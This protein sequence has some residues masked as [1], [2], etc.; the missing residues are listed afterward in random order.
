MTKISNYCMYKYTILNSSTNETLYL[1]IQDIF[2]LIKQNPD[3]KYYKILNGETI[4]IH[5]KTILNTEFICHR[6]NTV[7]ELLKI[8]TIFGVELDLRDGDYKQL[9]LQ[10]DPYIRGECFE[11][12]LKSYNH[13]TMI[14]NVKS[15]RIEPIC[16]EF[17]E[18]YDIKSYFFLD[19]N[20]PM[21]YLLS[22]KYNNNHIA[23]RFSEFEPI[24]S[25]RRIK[26]MVTWIWIDCFT[27]VSSASKPGHSNPRLPD[28]RP[29][30]GVSGYSTTCGAQIEACPSWST[31]PLTRDIY[32]EIQKD[33]IKICI[34]SPELQGRSHEIQNYR[35]YFIVNDILPDSICCKISNIIYWI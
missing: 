28:P 3:C 13:K 2:E 12:Y 31:Q 33:G 34:V 15:E 17:M 22:T 5:N 29:P 18:K 7:D 30:L 27:S 35:D 24:E 16:I 1:Y 4:L 11:S 10:H 20:L 9:Y 32:N 14:L 19:S 8:P 23:C 6:I 21:I 25:Y 26:H